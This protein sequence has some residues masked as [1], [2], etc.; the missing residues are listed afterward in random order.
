MRNWREKTDL[1]RQIIII[2]ST[3]SELNDTFEFSKIKTLKYEYNNASIFG[4]TNKLTKT[5]VGSTL[6]KSSSTCPFQHRHLTRHFR[7]RRLTT[8]LSFIG[9]NHH[10]KVV[11][12]TSRATR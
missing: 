1:F 7:A 9:Q 3:E 6:G 5:V 2:F 10:L 4:P 11:H 12:M 8:N